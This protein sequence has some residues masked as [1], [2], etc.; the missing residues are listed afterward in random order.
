MAPPVQPSRGLFGFFGRAPAN[1]DIAETTPARSWLSNEPKAPWQSD[2]TPILIGV[3]LPPL[4]SSTAGCGSGQSMSA[5]GSVFEVCDLESELLESDELLSSEL[6][7][8]PAAANAIVP[9]TTAGKARP[10]ITLMRFDILLLSLP[11]AVGADPYVTWSVLRVAAH[12]AGVR[13]PGTPSSEGS[14]APGRRL[15]ASI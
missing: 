7:P 4:R 12:A 2:S 8:Q 5:S 14:S 9:R 11:G 13:L 10:R 6:E 15:A 1:C 3:P